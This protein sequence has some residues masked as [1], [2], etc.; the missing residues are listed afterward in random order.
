MKQKLLSISRNCLPS[1]GMIIKK[2]NHRR[3][4]FFSHTEVQIGLLNPYLTMMC[5]IK[6]FIFR[7]KLV[8]HMM[9]Q[10]SWWATYC[11]CRNKFQECIHS[12]PTLILKGEGKAIPGQAQ[13]VPG[14]W[15]S[16]ISRQLAHEGGK[17]VSPTHRPTLP[18]GN[19]PGTHFC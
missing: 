2:A 18:P 19:I 3:D 4:S 11:A 17:V 1:L 13:R 5:T 14:V 10:L 12:L 6:E 8:R 16:Q 9:V 15:G 7:T